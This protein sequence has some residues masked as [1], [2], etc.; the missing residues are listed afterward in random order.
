[1]E[2]FEKLIEIFETIVPDFD[3]STI[4]TSS[5]IIEDLG[6]NSIGMFYMVLGIE[7]EFD[8]TLRNVNLEALVT[9]QDVIDFIEEN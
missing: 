8:V 6:L 1:M 9:I 5:K 7:K 4:S 3:S 2:T